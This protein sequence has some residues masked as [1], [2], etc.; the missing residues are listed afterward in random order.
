[1]REKSYHHPVLEA[2]YTRRSVRNY[3]DEPLDRAMVLEILKAASWAPSGLNNQPW[4]FA[5]IWD[6]NVRDDIGSLS[7]YGH[8]IRRAPVVVTVFLDKDVSYDYVKDCQAVGACLQNILLAAHSLGIGAVWIGEILASREEV[9]TILG[10][11][12]HLELMAVVAMG[13]PSPEPRSSARK[14]LSE[15]I[16]WER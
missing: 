12:E 6:S 5:L 16:V 14:P 2:I 11:D 9:R 10:L 7:R 15:L 3:R 8:I 13:H 1:M 4:R